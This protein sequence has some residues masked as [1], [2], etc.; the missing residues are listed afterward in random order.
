L[1][2]EANNASE[3]PIDLI[4]TIINND[5]TLK[6][7]YIVD[8][9]V[10]SAL[11]CKELLPGSRSKVQYPMPV[12][13]MLVPHEHALWNVSKGGSDTVTRFTWNC[14]TVLPIK[15]PQ[16]VMIARYLM[17]YAVL[18]HRLIQAVTGTK[19]GGRCK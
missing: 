18:A 6:E 11:I 19:R 13:D 7:K 1:F 14:L 8:D 10:L 12:C 2:Y 9:L 16:T 15:T 17:I 4:K 3:L 5:E